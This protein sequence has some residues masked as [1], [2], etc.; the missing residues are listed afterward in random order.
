MRKFS[1]KCIFM[2]AFFLT[3]E[4][5]VHAATVTAASCSYSDVQSAYNSAST[6]DTIAIPACSA[7]SWGGNTLTLSK[8]VTIQ[9]HTTCSGTQS[10]LACTDGTTIQAGSAPSIAINVNGARV[11]GI[12]FT[13][14]SSSDGHVIVNPAFTGWRIDHNSFKSSASTDRGV[15]VHGGYGLIDHNYF[16]DCDDG[17]AVDGVTPGDVNAGDY[18]WSHPLTR[19]TANEVYI[20]D[21][22]FSYS[23]VLDG[24]Y[25]IYNGARVVFRF[26]YVSGT[27]I[28]NHGLDSGGVGTRSTLSEEIYGNTM[29]GAGFWTAWNTRGGTSLMFGNTISNYSVFA[30]LRNYRATANWGYGNGNPCNGGNWI[31]GNVLSYGYPCRDQ[32]GRGPETTPS[33]DWPLL[34]S[35]S[36]D[37]QALYPDYF[38]S[39]AFGGSA[40][41]VSSNFNISDNANDSMPNVVSQYHIVENRDFYNQQASFNGTAGVGVGQLSSRPSTCGSGV[42]YWATDQGS[43]NTS[44]GS[45]GVLYKCT[46]TNNWTSYYTP[47]TYPHP[48][49]G[50]STGNGTATPTNLTAVV[51]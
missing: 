35:S 28:G 14:D 39:N 17:V 4:G 22:N 8:A 36:V 13:G 10:S 38:W 43:W 15:Y 25:D 5:L 40:P 44:G 16:R 21:N 29:T 26:N 50:G 51:D 33:T 27:T 48:L 45:Q 24:A 32:V 9:G 20:E 49:Q 47:Y 41:T 12:T 6:G 42:A 37:S 30:D 7:N 19:G 1:T 2:L 34:S 11:T 18:S 23:S 46:S 31:D 3:F